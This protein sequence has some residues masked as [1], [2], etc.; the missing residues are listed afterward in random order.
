MKRDNDLKNKRCVVSGK[1]AEMF[2]CLEIPVFQGGMGVGVSLGRLAG[3]V[4]AEGGAGT[5]STAQIGFAEPDFAGNP[6]RANLRAIG[7]EIARAKEIAGGRG[8][9]GVNIM[10]VTKNYGEYVREAVR[11]G[12]DFIVS[13]A[14][15]PM[16]LPFFTKGSAVK[17]IPIV[18]SLK[19]ASVICR[20]WLKKENEL[21]DAVII[22][23]PLAGGHLGFTQEEAERAQETVNFSRLQEEEGFSGSQRTE[24][25]SGLQAG[26]GFSGSQGTKEFSGLREEES[27]FKLQ[28][29]EDFSRL[30]ENRK[31]PGE[32][33]ETSGNCSV[34][35]GRNGTLGWYEEEV[36]R[37]IRFVREF[38]KQHGK[39]IPVITAGGFR[40][41][42]DLIHQKELG[43]DGIQAATRFVVTE[44]CDAARQFKEAY[45]K[46]R[47]EDIAI[48]KS[49]VGM[50]GRA[51]RNAFIRQVQKH[52]ISPAHCYQCLSVCSP[53]KTPYCITQ[54]LINAVTGDTENGLIFCGANAWREDRITT[55]REVLKEYVGDEMLTENCVVLD[56][57]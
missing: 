33:E 42:A 6:M 53:A 3:A 9:V 5:I 46:C 2:P 39:Y 31:L 32:E 57:K 45:V 22:E 29:A 37:I 15:L 27:F 34:R 13:G 11:Q 56:F 18:S 16:D 24:E 35:S 43:A 44:E 41:H 14:G 12:A 20:R 4:A 36:R 21:P 10:T 8:M 7:K 30:R 17:K 23:G 1:F 55:V 49:P 40:T 38:G 48:I 47:K 52:R 25:F 28:R 19:A 26:E 54:A 51:I 50:P